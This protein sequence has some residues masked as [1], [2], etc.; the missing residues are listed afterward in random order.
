ELAEFVGRLART[1]VG[2]AN[3]YLAYGAMRRPAELHVE[4]ERTLA[5][6]YFLYNCSQEMRGYE[7]RGTQSVPTVLQTA[8]R[9]REDSFA[10]LLLNLADSPRQVRIELEPPADA[11]GAPARLRL[12]LIQDGEPP[13]DL[14]VLEERRTLSL[15]LPPR[16]PVL[17]EGV[18]G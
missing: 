12:A 5:L 15:T 13:A 9:Y 2:T 4:G 8:W 14:G 11:G 16:C 7:S 1:R 3:R 17:V 10:W 18:P 6:S